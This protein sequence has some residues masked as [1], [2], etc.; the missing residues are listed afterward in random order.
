[1]S[2]EQELAALDADLRRLEAEYNMFFS[3][4][5]PR[6]PWETRKRVE[7]TVKR[8]D[9]Q[10]FTN[11]GHRFRLETLQ[12][13]FSAFVE[14]W[15][16]GLRSRE[17]GQAGPFGPA[18][19]S[20]HAEPK[21]RVEDGVKYVTAFRDP[22]QEMDKLQSLYDKLADARKAAGQKEIP[23]RRFAD[24]I[25][26]QV[27][28]QKAKGTGEVAFRVTVKDGKVN[29]TARRMKGGDGSEPE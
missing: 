28:A 15:D 13:R 3:G 4:R 25:R 6:P 5:L 9:R 27:E 20:A 17:T 22:M 29:F 18:P 11:Y 19:T 14:L 1:V 16:R 23:F 7:T 21:E 8:L 12:S 26:T 10:H 2:I 24:L